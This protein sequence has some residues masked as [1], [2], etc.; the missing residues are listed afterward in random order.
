MLDIIKTRVRKLQ[1]VWKPVGLALAVVSAFNG[2]R[3]FQHR[4]GPFIYV[5]LAFLL[6]AVA[7]LFTIPI[8]PVRLLAARLVAFLIDLALLGLLTYDIVGL[9]FKMQLIK[10]SA[11][12]SM[13]VVWSWLL[14]FVLF[15]WRF[16]GTPG[17]LMLGLRLRSENNRGVTLLNSLARSLLILVV[18]LI[19]PGRLLMI[20]TVSKLA[21]FARWSVG[22]ALLS[23]IPLS[24]AFSGGQSLPDMLVGT[25]VLPARSSTNR[26][27]ARLSRR[28]WLLLLIA[29]LL[30]GVLFAV[31]SSTDSLAMEVRP[32]P[33]P[34]AHV[35]KSGEA[36]ARIAA[37]LRTY[38]EAGLPN[39]ADDYL[40][41]VRVSSVAG[42]LPL[43]GEEMK[44]PV[45]CLEV[46]Q[47]NKN[48]QVVR[49]QINAQTPTFI[50]MQL[51]ENLSKALSLY[52]N[53]PS[54]LVFELATKD[55]YG[56]FNIET[57]E[58]YVLCLMDSKSESDHLLVN[59]NGSLYF[60]ASINEVT[61]LLLGDLRAYSQIENVPIWPH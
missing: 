30:S 7:I 4:T 32:P 53:R 29:S 48:Y 16:R 52:F 6:L 18:P 60:S 47:A 35:E 34:I 11:V 20:I 25:T 26:Y 49:A 9:L 5:S 15:D 51:F 13:A 44:A 56:V 38:L 40:Q 55:S 3:E 17:K 27:P 45:S 46:F 37:K 42:E 57:S 41:D 1:E 24:V 2:I 54:F 31:S 8:K 33:S 10:P 22:I 12:V 36:E 58:N 39:P 50:K 43:A 23:L 28:R 61:V 19:A 14:F 59:L 21:T